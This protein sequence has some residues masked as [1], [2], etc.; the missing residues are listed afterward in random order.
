MEFTPKPSKIDN[1]FQSD[2][3]YYIPKY[4]R[5]YVWKESKIKELLDDIEFSMSQ[6]GK[7]SYFLG[8]FIF[9]QDKDSGNKVVIDGQ[10]RLTSILILNSIICKFF[11]LLGDNFNINET[12][13]Y[14]IK[15]DKK[16]KQEVP[17]IRNDE[18]P[19]L[20]YIV[21][22]C[23]G[24]EYKNMSFEEYLEEEN[25]KISS[26]DNQ[27]VFC[28]KHY[29][30]MLS[31]N[32]N[33]Y[34]KK[35]EKIKYLEALRDSLLKISV[36]EISVEDDQSASLV[37]ET[38]NARGQE[39]ET[40]ELIKNYLYMYEKKV[41]GI[42]TAPTKWAK[43]VRNVESGKN[44]SLNKFIS[45]YMTCMFG[46]TAKK[47]MFSVF[48]H[49]T[50][51][52][53]VNSRLESLLT[54]SVIYQTIINCNNCLYNKKINSL[55]KCYADMGVSIIRPLL[56]SLFNAFNN[57][58]LTENE[59][60][61]YLIKLKNFLSIFV[62]IM[63]KKTNEI[64]DKI[65]EYSHLLT[66][67]F[68][69]EKLNELFSFF[70][71]KI[72]IIDKS[73]FVN[74]FSRFIFTKQPKK[75]IVDEYKLNKGKC[76]YILKEYELYLQQNDD[77]TISTFSIEHIKDDCLGGKACLLGNLIPFPKGKN[78]KLSGKSME[79]KIEKYKKSCYL[80]AQKVA[81]NKNIVNWDDEAIENRTKYLAEEFFEQ[82]WQYSI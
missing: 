28:Y 8:S 10:Q 71:E 9:Q 55:L 30:D 52:T 6:T 69:K 20:T 81:I 66:Q 41:R 78:N 80:S 54:F 43:I 60:I 13:K 59:F 19:V 23:L 17:R 58:N 75:H 47:E 27:V 5:K 16:I 65:Y 44:S 57:G 39:L 76:Q 14:C 24:D 53:E 72:S 68:E 35:N 48:K 61:N 29:L 50:P 77:Y 70:G 63:E 34:I 22:Y 12:K 73:T 18:L 49:G 26:N 64:E 82:V 21:D 42:S 11:I 37:F 56:M 79:Q 46:K 2:S 45:H 36:I 33:K 4:Q 31:N 32:L 67:N 74:K 62:C 1:I 3:F 7:I 40:H 15:G 51:R 38:I 25:Y